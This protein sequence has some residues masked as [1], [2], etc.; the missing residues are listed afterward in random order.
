[1]I[2]VTGGSSGIGQA[3]VALLR[4]QGLAV[5]APTRNEL[6]VAVAGQ[7][8]RMLKGVTTLTGLV[9]CAG[10]GLE[11]TLSDCT[12][13]EFYDTLDVNVGS[14]FLGM[15]LSSKVMSEG[16]S[17]VNVASIFAEHGGMGKAIAYQASKAAVLALTRNAAIHLAPRGIRVNA[18]LPGFTRTR[19]TEGKGYDDY[20]RTAP[21]KRMLEPREVAEVIA[22]LLSTKASGVT[23]AEWYV[24]GG[25][26]AR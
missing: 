11:G 5:L 6:D 8:F 22:F 14:V 19:L 4:E 12:S 24:D 23:G 26:N 1:M 17:I 9:N 2:L 18:V 20:A 21:M 25:W 13:D 3:T 10:I 15:A 16:A 7:W